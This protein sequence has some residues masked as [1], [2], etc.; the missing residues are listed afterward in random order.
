MNNNWHGHIALARNT[1]LTAARVRV[2]S[3]VGAC[4]AWWLTLSVLNNS[5]QWEQLLSS[6]Q[7]MQK[8][9][10]IDIATV[11]ADVDFCENRADTGTVEYAS[12]VVVADE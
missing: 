1:V 11:F 10:L 2:K 4:H 5:A 6:W 3:I 7:D 12:N 8:G 9:E